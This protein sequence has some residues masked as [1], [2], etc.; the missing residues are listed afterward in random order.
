MK[1][2]RCVICGEK[3]AGFRFSAAP[4]PGFCCKDCYWSK[5]MPERIGALGGKPVRAKS[6]KAPAKDEEG[7]SS[8]RGFACRT[9]E[10]GGDDKCRD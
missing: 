9:E 5:V 3:F 1:K 2:R 4:R 6:D 8:V 10:A 7:G